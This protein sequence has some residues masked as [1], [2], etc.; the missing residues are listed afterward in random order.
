MTRLAIHTS[1]HWQAPSWFK[2]TY[3]L[4]SPKPESFTVSWTRSEM[5]PFNSSGKLRN[6]RLTWK[7][8]APATG[9]TAFSASTYSAVA[10]PKVTQRSCRWFSTSE[11]YLILNQ[12]TYYSTPVLRSWSPPKHLQKRSSRSELT[13]S[14]R[15]PPIGLEKSL[16]Y[17]ILPRGKFK[18]RISRSP[19]K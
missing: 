14:R 8:T 7:P 10:S 4:S 13:R 17:S 12:K 6:L 16:N 2:T 15:I 1:I 19:M 9:A 18:L 11:I 5:L 3:W